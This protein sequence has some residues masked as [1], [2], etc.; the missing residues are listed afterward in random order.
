MTPTMSMVGNF[1]MGSKYYQPA[2]IKN[3]VDM[4]KV[5]CAV[6]KFREQ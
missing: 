4:T 1:M 6:Q 2:A 3:I 5:E